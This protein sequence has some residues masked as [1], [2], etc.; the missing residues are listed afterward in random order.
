MLITEGIV[1]EGFGNHTVKTMML[2]NRR[3]EYDQVPQDTEPVEA[4]GC[5][6]P[7]YLVTK[8]CIWYREED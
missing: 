4:G 8:Y 7:K 5:H 2:L 6:Q 1:E 3:L